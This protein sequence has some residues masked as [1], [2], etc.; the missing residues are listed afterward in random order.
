M[1]ERC[2]PQRIVQEKMNNRIGRRIGGSAASLRRHDK[3][4]RKM[5]AKGCLKSQAWVILSRFLGVRPWR[6][7]ATFRILDFHH[8]RSKNRLRAADDKVEENP[9]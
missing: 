4:E 2:L 1:E 8:V 5:A 6:W 7:R 9:E 3:V